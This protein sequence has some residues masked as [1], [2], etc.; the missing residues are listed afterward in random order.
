[1]GDKVEEVVAAPVFHLTD[2]DKEILAMRDEDY[3][4]Q[5]WEELKELICTSH[6]H[7]SM[8]EVVADARQH[9]MLWTS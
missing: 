1:M 9:R 4:L 8:I 2:K 7:A 6:L 3:K 5:T